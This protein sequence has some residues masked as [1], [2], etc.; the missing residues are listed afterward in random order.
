MITGLL[1]MLVMN[2]FVPSRE[3]DQ[4]ALRGITT[5]SGESPVTELPLLTWG[6]SLLQCSKSDDVKA[7]YPGSEAGLRALTSA[8]MESVDALWDP[9]QLPEAGLSSGNCRV[10]RVPS[11]SEALPTVGATKV[12]E[13]E[14]V[15]LTE[16]TSPLKK[17]KQYTGV[18][19][20]LPDGLECSRQMGIDETAMERLEADDPNDVEGVVT[21][22]DG[23]KLFVK[24]TPWTS[25]MVSKMAQQAGAY[26]SESITGCTF[27]PVKGDLYASIQG[28]IL[29]G[30]KSMG[31]GVKSFH[32]HKFRTE[33]LLF[34]NKVAQVPWEPSVSVAA[35]VASA[36]PNVHSGDIFLTRNDS[37]A[38][39]RLLDLDSLNAGPDSMIFAA[40]QLRFPL[41]L[42]V[43]GS[44]DKDQLLSHLS[45]ISNTFSKMATDPGL[46][47]DD[48]QTLSQF[49]GDFLDTH[50]DFFIAAIADYVQEEGRPVFPE[51][52]FNALR[53]IV[54]DHESGRG[55]SLPQCLLSQIKKWM[56]TFS[57]T[58]KSMMDDARSI[59]DYKGDMLDF[60][61]IR[62]AGIDV[63]EYEAAE[64]HNDNVDP[65][66]AL[67]VLT[68]LTG[69]QQW[70]R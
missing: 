21:L 33:N 50:R 53:K 64:F 46:A 3:S 5:V 10:A 19:C 45:D 66:L 55:D 2:A 12:N 43:L 15:P 36:F 17:D 13:L 14:T 27:S 61:Q 24:D 25:L 39:L 37:G 42:L 52:S 38:S 18:P 59:Y 69:G 60:R 32:N 48:L 67:H 4:G 29:W 47:E 31:E 49:N 8:E 41:K 65:Y 35:L 26:L 28:R 1:K 34:L 57:L 58:Y 11:K 16:A 7:D 54:A 68:R 70:V 6:P 30:T 40:Q 44:P 20:L 62:D 56:G 51:G 23:S 63:L 22:P 9:T